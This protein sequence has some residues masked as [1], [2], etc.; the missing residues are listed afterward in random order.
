[1]IHHHIEI[2]EIA[3][4]IVHI[5]HLLHETE[6]LPIPHSEIAETVHTVIEIAKVWL[7]G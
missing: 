5:I 7:I 1:M 6:L 2:A 4:E 3:I